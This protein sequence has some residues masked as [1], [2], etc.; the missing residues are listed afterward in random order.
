MELDGKSLTVD[1][2]PMFMSELMAASETAKCVR[3]YN[4]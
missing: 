4:T 2:A 1:S 3:A